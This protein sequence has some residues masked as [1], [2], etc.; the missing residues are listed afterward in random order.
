VTCPPARARALRAPRRPGGAVLVRGR[1][2][3]RA[4]DKR[5]DEP[6][7]NMSPS[8]S[9]NLL[10]TSDSLLRAL[11]AEAPFFINVPSEFGVALKPRANRLAKML[12]R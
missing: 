7:H 10:E 2:N 9:Y 5:I 11:E 4:F 3:R 8:H 1:G 12:T 6:N